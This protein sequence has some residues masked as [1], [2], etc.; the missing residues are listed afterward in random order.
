MLLENVDRKK[1][2]HN[3]STVFKTLREIISAALDFTFVSS[4][5]F[6]NIATD[7]HG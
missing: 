4:P 5:S 6:L 3:L 7:A 1:A 2:R